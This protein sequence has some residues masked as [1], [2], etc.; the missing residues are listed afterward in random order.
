MNT[1][2]WPAWYQPT[3]TAPGARFME[4]ACRVLGATISEIREANKTKGYVR[5]RFA[6]AH[7]MRDSLGYSYQQ[8]GLALGLNHSTVIYGIQRSRDLVIEDH[9]HASLVDALEGAI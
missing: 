5:R 9:N 3:V 6:L 2:P 8:I 4:R 7:V 1:T